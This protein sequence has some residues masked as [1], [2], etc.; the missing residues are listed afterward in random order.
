MLSG[1]SSCA[2]SSIA[3][4]PKPRSRTRAPAEIRKR[5]LPILIVIGGV[6][7]HPNV[8]LARHAI[9]MPADGVLALRRFGVGPP[10]KVGYDV[11]EL[12]LIVCIC[13]NV[14]QLC[15]NQILVLGSLTI[16]CSQ[17]I[18]ARLLLDVLPS[19]YEGNAEGHR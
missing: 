13:P 19:A 15:H 6:F 18:F 17:L 16:Q 7:A 3:T 5:V 9:G 1:R 4:P 14:K 2:S 11:H 12:G 8:A 10:G